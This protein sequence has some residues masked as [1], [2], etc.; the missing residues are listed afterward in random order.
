LLVE[1]GLDISCWVQ[2]RSEGPARQMAVPAGL[3]AVLGPTRP[4]LLNQVVNC[5]LPRLRPHG[6]HR[7]IPLSYQ[8]PG[9]G[10]T[11]RLGL[12]PRPGLYHSGQPVWCAMA[13]FRMPKE[14]LPRFRGAFVELV[15]VSIARM[16]PETDASRS[17][18]MD[19]M[20]KNTGRAGRVLDPPCHSSARQRPRHAPFDI[21]ATRSPL[22]PQVLLG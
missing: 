15:E 1:S 19:R 9:S 12:G 4:G 3:V 18:R 20:R 11:H 17:G 14:P 7:G 8:P 22:H 5:R 10:L 16:L 2:L 21:L 6:T 13:A